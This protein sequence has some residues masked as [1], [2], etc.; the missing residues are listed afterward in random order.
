MNKN[1]EAV[2]A[3]LLKYQDAL[4]QA[5]AEAVMKLYA[6]TAFSCRR[7]S[8]PAPVLTWSAKRMTPCSVQSH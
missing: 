6:P 1:E 5:D 4:N 3:V 8:R 2:A 7:T